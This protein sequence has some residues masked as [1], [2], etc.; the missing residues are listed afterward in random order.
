MKIPASVSWYLR[1]LEDFHEQAKKEPGSESWKLWAWMKN[2]RIFELDPFVYG[3]VYHAVDVWTTEVI[4][5]LEW[6]SEGE[7]PKEETEHHLRAV[8]S[9]GV[10]VPYPEKLPFEFTWIGYKE[11]VFLRP[12]QGLLR[13]GSNPHQL[14][15]VR[16]VGHLMTHHRE[17]Y[18]V[19]AGE[20]PN[21]EVMFVINQVHE[22]QRW[23]FP[24]MMHPWILNS[25][26]NAIN[27]NQTL[28][29]EGERSFAYKRMFEK[30]RK[31]FKLKMWPP[32]MW[33]PVNLKS[34]LITGEY[35]AQLEIHRE[36]SHRWDVRAHERVRVRRGPLPVADSLRRDLLRRGYRL[37][38]TDITEDDTLEKLRKR[39]LRGKGPE[40]WVAV[41][42]SWVDEHMK[43]P[44]TAP[45]VPAVRHFKDVTF[46][47]ER[48]RPPAER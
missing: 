10:H 41:L 34:E 32:P 14:T 13:L 40:E 21:G 48:V 7:I 33:Y 25:M 45:Y 47:P 35:Q 11:G 18:E 15:K 9:A 43:G 6:T 16:I 4:A 23:I 1:I 27:A 44:E 24:W 28:L 26:V 3:E 17:S 22:G 36:Y 30:A 42:T 19:S 29:L 46:K 5:G 37:F 8:H 38:E 39:G 20:T 12:H 2:A 31:K